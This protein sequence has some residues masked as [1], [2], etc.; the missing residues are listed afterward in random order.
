M[1]VH[2]QHQRGAAWAASIG[3]CLQAVVQHGPAIDLL[4]SNCTVAAGEPAVADGTGLES[5]WPGL[6]HRVFIGHA[7]LDVSAATLSPGRVALLAG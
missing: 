2:G 3:W 6:R 5:A 4:P 1:G 7:K